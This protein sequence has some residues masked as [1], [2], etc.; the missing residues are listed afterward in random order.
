MTCIH[1]GSSRH[2][3]EECPT[4]HLTKFILGQDHDEE[5]LPD[6]VVAVDEDDLF[7]AIDEAHALQHTSIIKHRK[8][9]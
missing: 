8:R 9:S 1:C 7:D 2:I 4:L 5:C 6:H 3:S